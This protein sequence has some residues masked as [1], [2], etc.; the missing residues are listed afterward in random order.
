MTGRRALVLVA[1]L[2]LPGGGALAPLWGFQR[3]LGTADSVIDRIVAVVGSKAILQSHVE[4]RLLQDFPQGKGLPRSPDSLRIL[5]RELAEVLVNE[6]LIVQ[7]AERDTTIKVLDED[8]TKSVDENVKATRA[9]Y[10]TE[11]QYR[12]DLRA[13]GFDS[14]E[15]YRSWLTEQQRRRLLMSKLM[16]KLRS[17]GKLKTVAPTEREIR[18]YYEKSKGSFPPR[19]AMISFRQIVIAPPPKPAAKARARAMADSILTEL[20]KGADFV[21]AAKR[22]SMDVGTSE[23]GGEI[24]WVRRGQGLDLH[25]EDVAFALRPGVVSDPVETPF[26]FHLIQVQRSQPAEV[27]VRHILIMPAV[28]TA[29]AD[30]ARRAAETVRG[31]VERGASFDSLQRIWHDK[32]E[33][34]EVI[35]FP[36]DSLPASYREAIGETPEGKL[37]RVFRLEA[38]VDPLRSKFA[39]LLVITRIPAGEAR[40]EDVKER[41]REGL[42]D[43]LTQQRYIERLRRATLVEMRPG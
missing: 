24:G 19:P 23:A 38:P 4:E 11:D 41:I 31:L 26:G 35:G 18:E 37:S 28:D 30:S 21:A 1:A 17:G 25:F 32:G 34:R 2:L 42:A 43:Q 3:G 8:V 14:P 9:R 33:E 39:V 7:E 15:E 5:R 22:Y 13:S 20:R 36:V 10:P 16:S 12:K 29:D 40:Y 6:E 27:Q